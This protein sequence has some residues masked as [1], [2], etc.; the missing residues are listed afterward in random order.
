[1]RNILYIFISIGFA[2]VIT[3]CEYKPVGEYERNADENVTPPEIQVLDL[4]L[5]NND[6]IF[7]YSGLE[8]AFRFTSL[9]QS[10]RNV[11]FTV[12][13]QETYNDITA[14]GQFYI[15][16]GKINE[17]DHTLLLEIVT[18]TGSGSIAE[19][20]G[21]EGFLFSKSWI[22]VVDKSFYS[23]STATSFNGF[24]KLVWPEY[25]NSDFKEY[26]VTR[27][28][29][30]Y[31]LVE[32]ERTINHEFID[33]SYV[34]EGASYFV[35]VFT[36]DG[37]TI[38]WGHPIVKPE[39]PILSLYSSETHQY[40][41]KWGNF[42]YYNAVGSFNLN[43]SLDNGITYTGVKSTNV[44]SDS[45]MI[46]SNA[47]FGDKL[48][49]RL[50]LVPGKNNIMYSPEN[51]LMFE[52]KLATNPGF[53]FINE[54]TSLEEIHQVSSDEF[55]G[56]DRCM[57]LNRYSISRKSSVDYMTYQPVSCSG[58]LFSHMV[59]SPA[60]KYLTSIY[61]LCDNYIMLIPSDNLNKYTIHNLAPIP[62]I[63]FLY[64]SDIGTAIANTS[65]SGFYIYDL[66]VNATI[67]QYSKAGFKPKGLSISSGGNYIF[68]TDDSVRL[69]KLNGS[70]FSNIW[71]DD[72]SN[73]PKYFGFDSSNPEQLAIWNGN[74][75]SIKD[76]SSFSTI[77]EFPLT[78]PT[79]I[80][81]DYYNKELLTYTP[82]TPGHLHIRDYTNGQLLS[83]I[84][85]NIDPGMWY[86]QVYL[87]NHSLVCMNGFMDFY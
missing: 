35:Q 62:Q 69:V 76:C 5:D 20:L 79:L 9:S 6:T 29:G 64:V 83:D 26:I 31:N 78:D 56:V 7:L 50:N 80:N 63:S 12:D 2:I 77:Y 33:S 60:G 14:N 39:L 54:Y 37:K 47:Y 86:T 75:L 82:G 19:H 11:K 23:K 49:F 53:K 71:S 4:N 85:I 44:Y 74:V 32:M 15:D 84:P 45:A 42:K 67:T 8:V 72:I 51:H 3:S 28:K 55:I 21:A 68:L 24:L 81:I 59:V 73:L 40:G 17:G 46:I 34:G 10:I 52:S 1:M 27:D 36:S 61:H 87:I 70:T 16:Y 65:S 57:Y 38:S 66:N 58:C 48:Y 30:S 25:R 41:I 43:Q 13:G 22:L 18:A